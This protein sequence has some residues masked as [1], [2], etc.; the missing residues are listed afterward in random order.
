MAS[1]LRYVLY[2]NGDHYFG[3]DVID[4]LSRFV[5]GTSRPPKAFPQQPMG[6][7]VRSMYNQISALEYDKRLLIVREKRHTAPTHSQYVALREQLGYGRR[8][9][10]PQV[11]ASPRVRMR[12][13]QMRA[14]NSAQAAVQ[15]AA[16]DMS[17][18]DD[19]VSPNPAP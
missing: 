4:T 14:V 2:L 15:A 10:V 3:R 5:H 17:W 12:D 1:K 7:C 16:A 8:I 13:P 19:F 9:R 11:P 6:M 18:L